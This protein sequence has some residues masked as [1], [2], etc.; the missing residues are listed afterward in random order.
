VLLSLL[1]NQDR[2]FARDPGDFPINIFIRHQVAQHDDALAGKSLDDSQQSASVLS[3]DLHTM[4]M[5]RNLAATVNNISR[6]H[7]EESVS[8]RTTRDR[9]SFLVRELPR[10]FASLR[11][12]AC[13]EHSPDLPTC[14]PADLPLTARSPIP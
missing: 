3:V 7:P 10:F 6:C 12:T 14:P 11:M 4:A 9:R 5:A 1:Q 2:R 13:G 8:L